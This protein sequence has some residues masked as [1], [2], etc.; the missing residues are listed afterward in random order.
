MAGKVAGV[1]RRQR[2]ELVQRSRSSREGSILHKDVVPLYIPEQGAFAP[3]RC[4][5]DVDEH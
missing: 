5:H 3:L 4:T 2:S 1:M